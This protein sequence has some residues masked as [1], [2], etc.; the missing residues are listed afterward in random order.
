MTPVKISPYEHIYDINLCKRHAFL[1]MSQLTVYFK[2]NFNTDGTQTIT[3]STA[4]IKFIQISRQILL[5]AQTMW[6]SQFPQKS[7][8][9]TTSVTIVR[10]VANFL[11]TRFT[12][13][14]KVFYHYAAAVSF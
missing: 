14:S 13:H 2:L 8:S 1:T 11:I 10:Q 4:A 3:F 7:T 9:S 12:M 6:P 5:H